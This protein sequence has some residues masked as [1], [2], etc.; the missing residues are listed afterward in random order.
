MPRPR[1]IRKAV[2]AVLVALLAA[3][4]GAVG[5]ATPAGAEPSGATGEVARLQ[6]QVAYLAEPGPKRTRCGLGWIERRGLSG[7]SPGRRR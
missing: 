3:G 1:P 5:A 4:A 6:R 7:S 2:A